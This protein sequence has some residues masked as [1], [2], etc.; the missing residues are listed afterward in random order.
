MRSKGIAGGGNGVCKK[1]SGV[2]EQREEA[3]DPRAWSVEGEAGNGVSRGG[4]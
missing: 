2:E 1:H 4:E 3:D